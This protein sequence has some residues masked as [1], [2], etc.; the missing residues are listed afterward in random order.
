MHY[1]LSADCCQLPLFCCASTTVHDSLENL[2]TMVWYIL[3]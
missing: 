3:V 2:V 1:P